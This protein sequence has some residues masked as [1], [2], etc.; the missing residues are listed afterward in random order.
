MFPAGGRPRCAGACGVPLSEG[1]FDPRA[2]ADGPAIRRGR[3]LAA[4][5]RWTPIARTVTAPGKTP[6]AW[7]GCWVMGLALAG[8]AAI[9][10]G[11]VSGR[12]LVNDDTGN[13][14]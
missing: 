13:E 12:R 8:C 7:P 5:R 11:I 6:A 4:A 9:G 2:G 10:V 14:R 3:G 1:A